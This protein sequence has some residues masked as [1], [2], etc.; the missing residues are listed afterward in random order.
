VPFAVGDPV[1]APVDGLIP[2]PAGSPVAD[3][4]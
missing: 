2:K 3:Q 4:L 1:I